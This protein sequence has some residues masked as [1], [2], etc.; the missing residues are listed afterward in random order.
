MTGFGSL[1]G[2]TIYQMHLYGV[3]G[4]G[5]VNFNKHVHKHNCSVNTGCALRFVSEIY[6]QKQL[7]C[8]TGVGSWNCT[9]NVHTCC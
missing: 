5:S 4:V 9:Q 8:V 1:N 2:N 7:L 6:L 3:T